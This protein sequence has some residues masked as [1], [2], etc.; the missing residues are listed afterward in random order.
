[1]SPV[2]IV[3]TV[4]GTIVLALTVIGVIIGVV[5]GSA[6]PTTP[7][8]PRPTPVVTPTPAW[9]LDR[10]A[11]NCTAKLKSMPAVGVTVLDNGRKFAGGLGPQ[12]NVQTATWTECMLQEL[13]PPFL[14]DA[15]RMVDRNAPGAY[16]WTA[17]GVPVTLVIGEH[18]AGT[19]SVTMLLQ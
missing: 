9:T 19:W 6:L 18:V 10:L 15:G 8:P 5:I 13:F 16:H 17:Q 2:K 1:M 3:L 12:Q 11:K 4:A 7:P 14:D